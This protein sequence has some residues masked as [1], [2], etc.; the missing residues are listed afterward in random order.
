LDIDKHSFLFNESKDESRTK[1]FFGQFTICL[2]F[3]NTDSPILS[4][5]KKYPDLKILYQPPFP[6][7]QIP[8][9]DYHISLFQDKDVSQFPKY[10]SLKPIF[11]KDLSQT[12]ITSRPIVA[13]AP[14]SGSRLKNWPLERFQVV[15]DYLELKGYM[16]YWIAGECEAPLPFRHND[17]LLRELDLI[18]LSSFLSNCQILIGN[19]SGVTHLAAASHCPVIALFGA[20][21][22]FIWA[23]RGPSL[24][25]CI[26]KSP[27]QIFCQILNQNKRCKSECMC[28]IQIEDVLK[29]VRNVLNLQ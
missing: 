19:D 21:N 14:G 1:S 7:E 15:A 6:S 23:P 9:V 20:S 22:P 18:A 25:K 3:T 24:T 28:S 26:Y 4:N 17:K 10:T 12:T 13:I 5:A 8:I 11:D 27:C 16:V 2:L 29:E